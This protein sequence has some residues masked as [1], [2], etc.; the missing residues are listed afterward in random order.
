MK[1]C[2]IVFADVFDKLAVKGSKAA[3][4]VPVLRV[5][6]SP[7]HTAMDAFAALRAGKPASKRSKKGTGKKSAKNS[8]AKV[9]I[10]SNPPSV[11]STRAKKSSLAAAASPTSPAM[12]G[13]QDEFRRPTAMYTLEDWQNKRVREKV[14][15]LAALPPIFAVRSSRA[16]PSLYTSGEQTQ[17]TESASEFWEDQAPVKTEV[18]REGKRERERDVVELVDEEEV[19][20]PKAKARPRVVRPRAE[21]KPTEVKALPSIPV[22]SSQAPAPS[23]PVD[24]ITQPVTVPIG[25]SQFDS[26]FGSVAMPDETEEP[27]K[28]DLSEFKGAKKRSFTEIMQARAKIGGPPEKGQHPLPRSKEGCLKGMAFVITGVLRSLERDECADLCK[29]L[30]GRVTGSVSGK[31]SVLVCGDLMPGASKTKKAKEKGIPVVNEAALFALI[32]EKSGYEP[33]APGV[34]HMQMQTSLDFIDVYAENT[35]IYLMGELC[36]AISVLL[37]MTQS[38]KGQISP[39]GFWSLRA[40][41]WFFTIMSIWELTD[42]PAESIMILSAPVIFAVLIHTYLS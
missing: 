19:Q 5:V 30:G 16:I 41:T 32:E 21:T 18:K 15:R 17:V 37:F 6:L 7:S 23:A 3:A 20:P 9:V 14:A 27:S 42:Y 1:G 33:L 2:S 8:P 29:R 28:K 25:Q 10:S 24:V 35:R 39:V 12:A 4:T 11:K 13:S 26:G 22:F 36:M 38:R 40:C 34:S 31:T